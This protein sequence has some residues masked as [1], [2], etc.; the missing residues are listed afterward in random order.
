MD[1]TVYRC[2]HPSLSGGDGKQCPTEGMNGEFYC[3]CA[4]YVGADEVKEDKGF[5]CPYPHTTVNA[6]WKESQ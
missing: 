3:Q 1:R 2:I 6:D 4:I 5:A